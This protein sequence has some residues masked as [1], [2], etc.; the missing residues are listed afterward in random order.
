VLSV[1]NWGTSSYLFQGLWTWWQTRK[2]E[3][4]RRKKW[5]EYFRAGGTIK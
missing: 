2:K 1:R 5:A 3:R 4:E